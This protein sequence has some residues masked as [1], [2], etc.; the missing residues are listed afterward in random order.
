MFVKPDVV[1]DCNRAIATEVTTPGKEMQPNPVTLV[2]DQEEG[3]LHKCI[4]RKEIQEP[5]YCRLA[6]ENSAGKHNDKDNNIKSTTTKLSS[7]S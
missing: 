2:K 4:V 1:N 7:Q 6:L 3:K 5:A